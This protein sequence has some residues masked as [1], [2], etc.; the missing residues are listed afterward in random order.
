MAFILLS[1]GSLREKP[2]TLSEDTQAA[3]KK[4]P[5]GEEPRSPA[6]SQRG[7]VGPCPQPREWTFQP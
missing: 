5:R 2:A 3:L 7:S 1:F 6:N 4:D